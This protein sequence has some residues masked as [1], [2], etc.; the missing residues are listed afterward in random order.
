[1]YYIYGSVHAIP[2]Y[3]VYQLYDYISDISISIS[4]DNLNIGDSDILQ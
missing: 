2:T 4:C 3:R 1:M